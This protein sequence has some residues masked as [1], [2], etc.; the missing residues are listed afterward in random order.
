MRRQYVGT[1]VGAPKELAARMSQSSGRDSADRTADV[2]TR[3]T[4]DR[5]SVS[6][7]RRPRKQVGGGGGGAVLLKSQSRFTCLGRKQPLYTD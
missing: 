6:R 4:V 3:P 5:R 1:I 7:A 2:S